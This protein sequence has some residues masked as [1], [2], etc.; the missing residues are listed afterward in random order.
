MH[1]DWVADAIA[2]LALVLSVIAL[3]YASRRNSKVE[4]EITESKVTKQSSGDFVWRIEVVNRGGVK[5]STLR[6]TYQ[7][8][9]AAR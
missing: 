7:V 3:V 5:R 8:S 1:M 4:W 2:G 6:C 9:R